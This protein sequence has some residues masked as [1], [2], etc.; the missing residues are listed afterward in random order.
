MSTQTTEALSSSEYAA[1]PTLIHEGVGVTMRTGPGGLYRAYTVIAVRRNGRELDI[2]EDTVH[3]A[4]TRVGWEDND[5]KTFEPNPKG[6]IE[7]ITLRNDGSFIV[8]GQPKEWYSTRYYIG[9]RRD[10]TDFSQ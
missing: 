4:G 9:Y 8:K 1:D 7:T 3:R 5:D 2:Q 6:R 10:W